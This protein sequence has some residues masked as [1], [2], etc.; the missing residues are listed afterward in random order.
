MQIEHKT[1]NTGLTMSDHSILVPK[2]AWHRLAKCDFFYTN[3]LDWKFLPQQIYIKY[4]EKY[5]S[6]A[7]SRMFN[8][9]QSKIVTTS[10]IYD[11]TPYVQVNK[12]I[13]VLKMSHTPALWGLWHL[14]SKTL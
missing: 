14:T 1:H 11:K 3:F 5:Y 10:W 8:K 12:N 2:Q 4:L 6:P 13:Q 9:K 7:F